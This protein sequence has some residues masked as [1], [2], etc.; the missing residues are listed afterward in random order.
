MVCLISLGKIRFAVRCFYRAI[1]GGG[2]PLLCLCLAVLLSGCVTPSLLS[3]GLDTPAQVLNTIGARTTEDGR[4]RFRQIFC[5]L[6]R[7]RGLPATECE[8]RLLRLADELG[9]WPSVVNLP[10]PDPSLNVIIVPGLFGECVSGF[11]E[12]FHL[13]AENLVR[14]GYRIQQVSVPGVS[15][16]ATNAAHIANNWK[17]LDYR[18]GDRIVVVAHSKGAVDSLRFIVDFPEESANI[19]ALVSVAGAINGSPLASSLSQLLTDLSGEIPPE[20]CDTGDLGAYDSLKRNTRLKWLAE[21][22]LPDR[23]RYLSVVGIARPQRVSAG[24]QLSYDLLANID[25]LNDGMLLFYDQVIP[26]STLLGYANADHWAIVYPV[27]E[28]PLEVGN[29]LA[30]R[31]DYPREVLLEAILLYISEVFERHE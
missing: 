9:D 5:E 16:D 15:A 3:P 26:G 8:Y 19:T 31:N 23:I 10:E 7:Q 1:P 27:E 11:V 12:P 4:Q 29:L 13:A 22:S 17:E 21:N 2:W 24:L 30:S 14:R 20:I 28:L 25:P 6:L 18:P